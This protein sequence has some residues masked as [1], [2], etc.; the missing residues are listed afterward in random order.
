[1]K[2]FVWA[3]APDRLWQ[4][5]NPWRFHPSGGQV[6]F[7][8]ILPGR[9]GAPEVAAA[10]LEEVGRYGRQI[11]PLGEVLQILLRRLPPDE[12]TAEER[13]AVDILEADLTM[14]RRI[15]RRAGR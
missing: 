3:L 8:N 1:M 2:P 12:L 15:K 6:G 13:E 5:I 11:G 4:A 10:A 7:V 14:L 9:S